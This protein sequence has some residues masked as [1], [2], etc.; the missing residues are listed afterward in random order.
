[1]RVTA[2]RILNSESDPEEVE[3]ETRQD[4]NELSEIYGTLDFGDKKSK[5]KVDKNPATGILG[6][7]FMKTAC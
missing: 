1:M 6:M 2:K 5:K 4:L 7:K 3:G